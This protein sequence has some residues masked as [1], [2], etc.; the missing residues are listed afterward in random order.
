[1]G[2]KVYR[3]G[4]TKPENKQRTVDLIPPFFRF[5]NFKQLFSVILNGVCILFQKK[6]SFE[7][8]FQNGY[9]TAGLFRRL[10]GGLPRGV[11]VKVFHPERVR[12]RGLQAVIK[13]ILVHFFL[14]VRK[15]LELRTV[16]YSKSVIWVGS[17]GK[18]TP[19]QERCSAG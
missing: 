9:E 2:F 1:M 6:F 16:S 19:Q 11:A 17:L 7:G 3:I 10:G 12:G 13:Q 5:L 8:F 15:S 14:M 4:S 18:V